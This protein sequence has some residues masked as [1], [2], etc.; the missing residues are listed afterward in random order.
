MVIVH[1][2]LPGL[3]DL[4]LHLTGMYLQ[5]VGVDLPQVMFVMKNDSDIIDLHYSQFCCSDV[6]YTV[7]T[8]ILLSPRRDSGMDKV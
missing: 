8:I 5:S 4:R 3:W 7:A 6:I 2:Q 1:L